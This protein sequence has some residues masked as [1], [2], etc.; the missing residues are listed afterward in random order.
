MNFKNT[1]LNYLYKFKAKI[2]R[3]GMESQVHLQIPWQ[4][5]HVMKVTRNYSLI[6]YIIIWLYLLEL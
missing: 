2:F 1:I 3:K 4:I 5:V 6:Y